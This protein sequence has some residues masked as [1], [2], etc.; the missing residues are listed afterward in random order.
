MVRNNRDYL[1]QV[2]W[3]MHHSDDDARRAVVVTCY[4]DESSTDDKVLPDGVLGGVLFNKSGFIAFDAAWSDLLERYGVRQPLHMKEFAHEHMDRRRRECFIGE[5]VAL[6]NKHKI[7]SL[8]VWLGNREFEQYIDE[9]VRRRHS[10]YAMAF[11]AMVVRNNHNAIH[12]NFLGRVAYLFDEGNN[13]R[14][15]VL[16]A[17]ASLKEAE[18]EFGLRLGAIGFDHDTFVTALQ[19]A[20]MVAWAKRRLKSGGALKYGLEPLGQLFGE[21]HHLDTDVSGEILQSLNAGFLKK[22]EAGAEI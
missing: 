13:K 7:V 16:S 21:E 14:S 6:V 17:H 4:V 8:T 2:W 3:L 22:I 5:A 9:R 10:V 11:I 12:N 15:H 20:D 19:A 18:D 1:E